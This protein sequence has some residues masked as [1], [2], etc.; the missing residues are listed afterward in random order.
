MK[1]DLMKQLKPVIRFIGYD[2]N[3]KLEQCIL[4]NQE[5]DSHRPEK[6]KEEID[7][8]ISLIPK[9]DLESI[10]LAKE[11]VL[12]LLKNASSC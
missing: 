10:H 1:I 6:S 4:K 9:E 11:N 7:K 3:K 2:I 8:I 5:G 12:K